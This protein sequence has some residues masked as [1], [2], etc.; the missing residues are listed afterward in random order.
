MCFPALRES[1]TERGNIELE[2]TTEQD[3]S[4]QDG[5]WTM[6]Q[7][8]FCLEYMIDHLNARAIGHRSGNNADGGGMSEGEEPEITIDHDGSPSDGPWTMC[9]WLEVCQE[10]KTSIVDTW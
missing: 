9:H 1:G 3:G 8:M 6:R 7:R 10:I 2:I 4:P 5:P